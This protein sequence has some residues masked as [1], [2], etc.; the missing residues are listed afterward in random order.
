MNSDDC[1]LG[2]Y[3]N[4]ILIKYQD[5]KMVLDHYNCH[6]CLS[7]AMKNKLSSVVIKH[8]LQQKTDLK[9][10]KLLFTNLAKGIII[11][12]L[13]KKLEVWFLHISYNILIDR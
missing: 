2:E 5:G 10:N 8:K 4:D 9:I 3:I 1:S 6:K 13:S 12:I 7:F 11:V